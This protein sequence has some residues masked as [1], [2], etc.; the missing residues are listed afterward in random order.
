MQGVENM[1]EEIFDRIL[2]RVP[3]LIQAFKDSLEKLEAAMQ[4]LA[5]VVV[6][7]IRVRAALT[8]ARHTIGWSGKNIERQLR[9]AKAWE[10]RKIRIRIR[11][12]DVDHVYDGCKLDDAEMRAKVAEFL[13]LGMWYHHRRLRD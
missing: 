4:G 1:L 6:P 10:D 3:D 9:E 13:D 11:R 8:L 7:P 12:Q 5:N 2:I